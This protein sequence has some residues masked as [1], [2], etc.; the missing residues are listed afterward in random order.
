LPQ[1]GEVR[2]LGLMAA[3]ELVDPN[4]TGSAY[5]DNGVSLAGRIIDRCMQNGMVPRRLNNTICM[6]PPL[7]ST[8][9]QLGRLVEVLAEAIQA[10]A[11]H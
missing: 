8:E 6:A 10:E 9:E 7:I 2:G 4:A 11:G 5:Y 3:V 1:V